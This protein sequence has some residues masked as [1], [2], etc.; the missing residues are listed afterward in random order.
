MTSLHVSSNANALSHRVNPRPFTEEKPMDERI[1][2]LNLLLIYLT[3][4][5]EDSKKQ[6]GS[7]VFKAWKGYLFEVLDELEEKQLIRQHRSTKLLFLTDE[8]K[9]RAQQLKSKYLCA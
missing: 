7:K 4:W 1:K 5:E 6:P 2:E 3:G 8:G 9:Q